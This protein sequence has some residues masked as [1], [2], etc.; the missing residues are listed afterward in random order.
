[1]DLEANRLAIRVARPLLDRADISAD[2]LALYWL[3]EGHAHYM[4][5]RYREALDCF[6]R[7]DA[8]IDEH[9]LVQRALVSGAWRCQCEATVGDIRAAQATVARTERRFPSAHGFASTLFQ[10][11]K[12][13]VAFAAGEIERSIELGLAAIEQNRESGSPITHA[14]LVP[15]ISY[16]LIASGRFEQGTDLIAAQQSQRDVIAYGHLGAAMALMQAWGAL[17]SKG[18]AQSES[19]LRD[20]LALARDE[21]DRLRLRWFPLALAELLPIALERGIETDI[22]LTLI[23]ECDLTPKNPL[24]EVWPWPVR[25]YTLGRFEVQV[26]SKPMMIGRKA[27][28][29][30]LALLKA[31]IAFGGKDVPEQRLADALWPEQDGDA[32]HESLAA[33]LHRLRRLLEISQVILQSNGMLSL[34][35][36]RCFVDAWAFESGLQQPGKEHPALRLY[37]GGFLEG[38]LD[39][40]W[41]VSMR[42]RLRSKFVRAVQTCAQCLEAETR[43]EEAIELY[44]RG[45][46]ADDLVEPFYQGVMRGYLRLGRMAEA[47]ATFHRLSRTLAAALSLD[48]SDESQRLFD[49]ASG[50]RTG[51]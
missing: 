17:R 21:R 4:F 35:A 16:R 9:G 3:A 42:E 23:K 25:I 10:S 19:A 18:A 49:A 27:P 47:T 1:L 29:R 34:N 14:L 44:S 2:R 46:E 6:D 15:R 24:I 36:E 48:P 37:R 31:I 38:D 40:Q 20:A 11:A 45:L 22:A 33:A 50:S 26:G 13:V 28:K 12:G 32:A 39:A 7:A 8:I 5:T 30:T 43:H 51:A 41:S